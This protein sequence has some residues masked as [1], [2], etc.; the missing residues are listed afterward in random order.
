MAACCC[1]NAAG[2]HRCLY[3]W[4]L[5]ILAQQARAR[6]SVEILT[7]ARRDYTEHAIAAGLTSRAQLVGDL[8]PDTCQLTMADDPRCAHCRR[9]DARQD[10]P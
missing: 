6:G 10:A 5:I 1:T 3:A 8:Y 4:Q 2:G 9:D 7:A